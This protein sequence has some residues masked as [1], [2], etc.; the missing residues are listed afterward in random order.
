VKGTCLRIVIP[1][2]LLLVGEGFARERESWVTRL[3]SRKYEVRESAKRELVAMGLDCLPIVAELLRSGNRDAGLN[4]RDVLGRLGPAVIPFLIKNVGGEND[5]ARY[6]SITVLGDLAPDSAPAV[7]HLARALSHADD[8]I[9]YE[10]AWALAALRREAAPAVAELARV[11]DHPNKLV[12]T[13]AAGA[14]GAIGVAARK[15]TPAL[16]ATLDDGNAATRRAAA[17]A[18]AS[19]GLSD[20][21]AVARLIVALADE[22]IYVRMS[23]ARVLGTI[24][25]AAKEALPAL[26]AAMKDPALAPDVTWALKRITGKQT[27]KTA[28]A[29]GVVSKEAAE[30]ATSASGW[31]MLGGSPA[32]NAIAAATGIPDDWDVGS[33]R[34]V[35][36][37]AELGFMNFGGPIVGGGR[38][39][40]GAGNEVR[41]R[42]GITERCGTLLAFDAEDG[43][44]LW[45][46]HSP[47]LGRQAD[48]LLPMTTSSPL[49]EGDRIY[50]VT[51]QCQLRC[52]DAAGF[53]DQQN[54]GPF[55]TEKDTGDAAADRIWELD[56]AAK[57]GVFPH[58]ASN[59][60]VISA[61]N[62]LLVCT[63]NGVDEAH[64]RVAS[65]RAPSFIGVNKKD[66]SVL[67]TC[68]GP[69]N[70]ILHGQWSSPSLGR[71]GDRRL[72]FF[73]GGDG[74]LYALEPQTGRVVW[75]FDGNA[76]NA[77]WRTGNDFA[78]VV[79]RN[80]II[81]CPLFDDGRVYLGLG[82]DPSH[83]RG[84]AALCAID[85][86]GE[87]DVSASRRIW[88]YRDIGR[89]ITTPIAR[90]GLIYAA[91]LN[92]RVHCID[93]ETG[94]RIWMH[95]TQAPIWGSL[96][97]L[98]ENLLVGNEDGLLVTLRATREKRIV[99]E[100]ELPS[101]LYAGPI[102][103]AGTL[104]IA[105]AE[106][107]Y[108]IRR[109]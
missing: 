99:R 9:V 105:T 37:S 83:G 64:T 101:A 32:R 26:Q 27:P 92:G 66:G 73:G 3:A 52:L 2:L 6:Y 91:D 44:L 74:W 75:R 35:L 31:C 71:V 106:T 82:Q 58:E 4:T 42:P 59:C 5:D 36:W 48:F 95:D 96:L 55:V 68:A 86:N 34:H 102:A 47:N 43:T 67:W 89:T 13:T 30:S 107:L 8:H 28:T 61:G 14:L 53:R 17:E 49:L 45:Q 78:G 38:V 39:F 94:R 29:S 25:P 69:G 11:L 80:S 90:D 16:L 20:A 33:G 109:E 76:R 79:R 21:G 87:G 104:Y 81:A 85:P 62:V 63:S 56:L 10:A 22:N 77:V 54:D 18:L 12:R 50:Y 51:A 103:F 84:R 15:S 7:P 46:D 65:P 23:V 108:A 97:L 24:G 88:T 60:S 72:A 40:I 19:I 100:I 93:A 1:I 70:A 41:Q 57:L 98:G